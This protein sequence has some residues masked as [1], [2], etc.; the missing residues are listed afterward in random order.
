MP[1]KRDNSAHRARESAKNT[2][3]W[4]NFCAERDDHEVHVIPVMRGQP[5]HEVDTECWCTPI[6]DASYESGGVV[7]LHRMVQ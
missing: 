3:E 2:L 4:V 7:F 1:L 5:E 6:M